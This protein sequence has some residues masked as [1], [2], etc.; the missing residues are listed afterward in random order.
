MKTFLS[1]A[2]VLFCLD[3]LCQTTN[4]KPI[5]GN[6]TITM[7]NDMNWWG[8]PSTTSLLSNDKDPEGNAMKVTTFRLD[9]TTVDKKANEFVYIKNKAIISLKP[10]GR[11]MIF[12]FPL[13]EGVIN[14]SYV[15]NDYYSTNY[16]QPILLTL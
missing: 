4:K 10:D 12:P 15:V 2:I 13:F 11:Y 6:D 8:F 16:C 14:F 5:P 3:S 9:S 7:Y 1:I